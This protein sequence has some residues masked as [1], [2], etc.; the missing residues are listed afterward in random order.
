MPYRVILL[1]TIVPGNSPPDVQLRL[2][3]L[4]GAASDVA[5]RLLS[6]SPNPIKRGLDAAEAERIVKALQGIGALARFEDEA[7]V[8]PVFTLDEDVATAL[9]ET[10]APAP[11]AT[12]FRPAPAAVTAAPTTE[13]SPL[14]LDVMY[15]AVIGPKN[16]DFYLKCF[17]R[18]D[19]GGSFVAWH[20]PAFFWIFGWG[21]YRKLWGYAFGG[22]LLGCV[23]SAAISAIFYAFA[24]RPGP[25]DQSLPYLLAVV[26]GG[27]VPAL[28]AIGF[29]HRKVRAL[30][31]HTVHLV[32]SRERLRE[33]IRL[34]GTSAWWIVVPALYATGIVAAIALPAY[35]DYVKRTKAA[36]VSAAPA[37]AS[38]PDTGF[39]PARS[40]PLT[41]ELL[42]EEIR[43]SLDV[44]NYVRAGVLAQSLLETGSRDDYAYYILG[45]AARERREFGAALQYFA[46]ADQLLPN[47][48]GLLGVIA[49]TLYDDGQVTKAGETYRRV[50][51][52]D[53]NHQ[54]AR[55]WLAARPYTKPAPDPN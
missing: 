52:L 46:K 15:R 55:E 14:S 34:G 4:T 30:I 49:M 38:K 39:D 19:A 9:V 20:W 18:R 29:Y 21:L 42:A 2:Q 22:A 33:L 37:L 48:P 54:R 25:T 5:L 26:L 44:H 50:L 35:D 27:T 11:A 7:P 16:Q 53:P 10:P 17:A 3:T 51:V 23:V 36:A 43:K 40:V 41:P 12:P 8:A 6:G 1:G 47:H 28:F 45:V 31:G 32:D 24:S 13:H